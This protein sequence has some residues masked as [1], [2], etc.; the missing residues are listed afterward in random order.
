MAENT[1]EEPIDGPEN[2]PFEKPS[3]EITPTNDIKTI[4]PNQETEN[5]EV[6]KHPH[7]VTH[8]K[9]WGEYL[10]EFLMLFLAVFL[11]FVAENIRET[12][13]EH[14]REKEYMVTMLE[15]LKADMPLLVSTEKDWEDSNNSADS[16]VDAITFPI[17]TA[18][19][20]KAYRHINEALNYWSFKYNDRTTAQ[21]KN[22]GGFRLLHNKKVA[23]KIIAYDQFYNDA[24]TN[25]AAQHNSY[26]ET[27]VKLRNKVFVQEIIT[28]IY[29]QYQYNPVPISANSW[30]DSMISKN[31]IPLQAESQSALMFEFKNAL[32]S[33][34]QD[35]INNVKGGYD[36][37]LKYQQELITLISKEYNLE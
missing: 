29:S 28:K 26:W 10:L 30:I 6:H 12:S 22:A 1:K 17:A 36:N 25:M 32:L 18:D 14:D 13:V 27:V 23:N 20:R 31:R 21:L 24:M 8:K 5:M 16:V 3:E 7:H 33:Y 2:T 4:N 35:Y 9:K 37:L 34:K 11:G 19:L 15:D